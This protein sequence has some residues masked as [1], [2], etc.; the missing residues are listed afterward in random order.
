VS[1]S[2]PKPEPC[3]HKQKTKK[4]FSAQ[5]KNLLRNE[6]GG[7]VLEITVNVRLVK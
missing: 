6:F 2:S 3:V 1:A 5:K 7:E 4:G